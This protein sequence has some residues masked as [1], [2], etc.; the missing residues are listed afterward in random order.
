MSQPCKVRGALSEEPQRGKYS[1][2]K[3]E[4]LLLNQPYRD[5][6]IE[7]RIK[8]RHILMLKKNLVHFDVF[9]QVAAGAL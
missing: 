3:L 5:L 7:S 1:V 2:R 8:S 4:K 9:V 6:K